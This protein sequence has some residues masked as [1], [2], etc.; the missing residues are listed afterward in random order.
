MQAFAQAN[1]T[2]DF[3]V[4]TKTQAINFYTSCLPATI[5][6]PPQPTKKELIANVTNM[7][8]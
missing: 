2:F 8:P 6:Y 7:I 4:V 1:P 5:E 3:K